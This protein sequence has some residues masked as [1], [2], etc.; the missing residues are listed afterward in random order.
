MSDALLDAIIPLFFDGASSHRAEDVQRDLHI[1]E[2][3]GH[4]ATLEQPARVSAILADF[5]GKLGHW[6]G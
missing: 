4:S 5:L 1:L 3:C 6:V 2:D